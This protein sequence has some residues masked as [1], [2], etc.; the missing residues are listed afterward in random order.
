MIYLPG[1]ASNAGG[2]GVSGF[3]MSQNAGQLTWTEEDVDQKSRRMMKSIYEQ[4]EEAGTKTGGTLEEGV[5]RAGFIKVATA[6]K[7]L[8]WVH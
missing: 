3:E 2:V 7:E 5:N 8:G 6:M 1:K 4:M